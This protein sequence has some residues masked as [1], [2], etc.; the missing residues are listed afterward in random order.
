MVLSTLPG[1][2]QKV[3][4]WHGNDMEVS[5]MP[6]LD[7]VVAMPRGIRSASNTIN[8]S[9]GWVVYALASTSVRLRTQT[10]PE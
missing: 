5:F 8:A 3:V 2:G 1:L 6:P 4:V 7:D 10:K 9:D